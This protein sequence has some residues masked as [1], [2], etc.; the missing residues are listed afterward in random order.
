[1]YGAAPDVP[2]PIQLHTESNESMNARYTDSKKSILSERSKSQFTGRFIIFTLR[3]IERR[4]NSNV[5][6]ALNA[7]SVFSERAFFL[8]GE[9]SENESAIIH[10]P[11]RESIKKLI[12]REIFSGKNCES[13]FPKNVPA[14]DM[15]AEIIKMT[16]REDKGRRIFFIP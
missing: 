1:M 4:S 5:R 16:A 14:A 9:K 11:R 12:I 7:F 3:Y 6:S 15:R 13:A 8:C 2:K 10:I